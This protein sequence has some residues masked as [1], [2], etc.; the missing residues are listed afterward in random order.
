MRF[1][2][3]IARFFQEVFGRLAA[4]VATRL[5]SRRVH[6]SRR[7]ETCA[8]RPGFRRG[9]NWRRPDKRAFAGIRYRCGPALRSGLAASPRPFQSLARRRRWIIYAT[10][11]F[12]I[13][14]SDERSIRKDAEDELPYKI[15]ALN[16]QEFT[17][18]IRSLGTV[19]FFK[20][21]DVVSK[22]VGRVDELLAEEGDIV[23]R[24]E[25]LA[26]IETLDLDIQLR[27]DLAALEVQE[28]QIGL[29]RARL[30]E[31]RRE[32]TKQLAL[33]EKA[34]ADLR[35]AETS[36]EN[37]LRTVANKK[38]L[39]EIGAVS[40]SE[41]KSLE[42]SLVSS[43]TQLLKARK[44]LENILI[45]YRPEDLRTAGMAVPESEEQRQAAYIE[46][47]TIIPRAEYEM[48]IANKE[49]TE[50]NLD[51]TRLLL[52]EAEIRSPIEGVVASRAIERGEQAKDG[53]PLFV[54]V[55]ISEVLVQ[56]TVS[57]SELWRIEVGQRVDFTVDAYED[58]QY[59]GEIYLISPVVD[60]QSRTV[61]IKVLA[62]NPRRE[63]RPGM[64]ARGRVIEE[65]PRK[66]FIIP[67][68]SVL[69]GEDEKSGF[70]FVVNDQGLLF[71]KEVGL[72][73]STEADTIRIFGDIEEGDLIAVGN[74]RRIQ[75]GEPA[76]IPEELRS[77]LP[78]AGAP[79][80]G[81]GDEAT[82]PES[83]A[84]PRGIPQAFLRARERSLLRASSVMGLQAAADYP[85]AIPAAYLRPAVVMPPEIAR[86]KAAAKAK[87]ARKIVP[88]KAKAEQRRLKPPAENTAP[89]RETSHRLTKKHVNLMAKDLRILAGRSLRAPPTVQVE[90]GPPP[91]LQVVGATMSEDAPVEAEIL[92]MHVDV[93]PAP[94]ESVDAEARGTGEGETSRVDIV[95]DEDT[96][97]GE[98]Y[99]DDVFAGADDG[100]AGNE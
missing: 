62:A 74:V 51:S 17:T 55:D 22:I 56:F 80:S 23:N 35:D 42:A 87:T 61:P 73:D 44:D 100:D 2:Q 59:S 15:V 84:Q 8:R 67:A 92:E 10:V 27:K 78:E 31:A 88:V 76:K 37:L 6:K 50:A 19:S 66:G 34:R 3:H 77:K 46:L 95:E 29:A 24:G 48:A 39:G 21:T 4:S 96:D 26:Q 94:A 54:V 40:E 86:E 81:P 9:S 20:K 43:E 65:K 38:K 1:P 7:S 79:E 82:E 72:A 58:Q 45:G 28:R 89:S 99:S 75:E 30:V 57:E 71:R 25:K 36:H 14:C 68:E 91:A 32:V 5:A 70:I 98:R 41:L 53:E 52:R 12:V 60:P 47:N 49:S 85:A 11:L 63:L 83:E 93:M 64:F 33:I 18:P 16:A 90:P 97:A 69:P 13:A